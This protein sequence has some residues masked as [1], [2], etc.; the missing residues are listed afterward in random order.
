MS[1]ACVSIEVRG[2]SV[3]PTR[4]CINSADKHVVCT[5]Y[6][7]N[8]EISCSPHSVSLSLPRTLSLS[9]FSLYFLIYASALTHTRESLHIQNSSNAI[10]SICVSPKHLQEV[11]HHLHTTKTP[12]M[13]T[14]TMT[15][16]TMLSFFANLA[17]LILIHQYI[18]QIELVRVCTLA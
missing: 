6:W 10:I 15:N 16:S 8:F 17:I 1:D 14:F 7:Y 12:L 2:T 9:L 11:T 3:S 18:D 13:T 5:E 4:T